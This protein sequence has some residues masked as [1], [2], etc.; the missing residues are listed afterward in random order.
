MLCLLE[1]KCVVVC[2]IQLIETF[3]E[4]NVMMSLLC[5]LFLSMA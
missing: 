4:R 1:I 2:G 5:E 3:Y